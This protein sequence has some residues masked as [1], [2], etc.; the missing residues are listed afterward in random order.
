M[1]KR[2]NLEKNKKLLDKFL[3]KKIGKTKF[4]K[5]KKNENLLKIGIIDSMD[6]VDINAFIEKKFNVKVPF[7]EIY[8]KNFNISISNIR[9]CLYL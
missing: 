8:G 5:I 3:I 9:K 2:I 7:L 6:L 4:S 1:K